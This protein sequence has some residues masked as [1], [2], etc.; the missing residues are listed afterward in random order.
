MNMYRDVVGSSSTS[1]GE[2]LDPRQARNLA[3]GYSYTVD[4]FGQLARFLILGTSGGTYY[5]GER[6]LTKENLQ[7]VERLLAA[8]H[9]RAIVDKIVEI[10]QA[11]RAVSNDPALFALARCGS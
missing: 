5:I 7:V 2:Q 3:G 1:Q 11:G 6:A 4:D 10:S 9:G 8:G